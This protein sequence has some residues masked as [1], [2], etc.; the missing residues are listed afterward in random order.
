MFCLR[1]CGSRYIAQTSSNVWTPKGPGASRVAP[2]LPGGV[3]HRT[4]DAEPYDDEQ[5]EGECCR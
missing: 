3:G 2:W 1:R 4:G 5:D